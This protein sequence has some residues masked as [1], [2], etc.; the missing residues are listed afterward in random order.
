MKSQNYLKNTVWL[1]LAYNFLAHLV[2]C[3]SLMH[4]LLSVCHLE[5]AYLSSVITTPNL[6]EM[7]FS[8]I[9]SEP[10]IHPFKHLTW[11]L[12]VKR[13]DIFPFAS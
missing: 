5:I 9:V 8:A 12:L 3:I 7:A 2:S 1:S 13:N 10:Q 6:V 4:R 11:I